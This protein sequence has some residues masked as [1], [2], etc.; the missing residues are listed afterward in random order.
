MGEKRRED[1]NR[2]NIVNWLNN[3]NEEKERRRR[4]K[5]RKKSIEKGIENIVE[6]GRKGGEEKRKGKR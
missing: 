2:V 6:K 4:K 1:E 3:V 5:R